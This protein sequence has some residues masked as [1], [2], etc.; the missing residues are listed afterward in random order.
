VEPR[1]EQVVAWLL[2]NPAPPQPPAIAPFTPITDSSDDDDFSDGGNV[3]FRLTVGR[4][5][6]YFLSNQSLYLIC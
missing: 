2:E 3:K 1:I 6:L 5:S 4:R